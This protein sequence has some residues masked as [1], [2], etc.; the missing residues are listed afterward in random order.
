MQDRAFIP[1]IQIR[2]ASVILY[3]LP[4]P[5]FEHRRNVCRYKYTGI[6]TKSTAKRIARTCDILLQI[7]PPKTVWNPITQSPCTFRLTFL[8]LT[9]SK[10][11]AVSAKEGYKLGLS[12]FLDWLRKKGATEYIWKAELQ[13]RGQLHYHITTNQFLRFDEI[14]HKWN[15]LQRSAGWSED[16]WKREG[17]WHPN[18]T[19]IHAV[20]NVKRLD[21]YLAKYMAKGDPTKSIDGKVWG[22]SRHLMG[23]RYYSSVMEYDNADSIEAARK[24]KRAELTRLEH[25]TIV[26][27]DTPLQILTATQKEQYT[28]WQ[29]TRETRRQV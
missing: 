5:P 3:D 6:V 24:A 10:T 25:C 28:N 9:I 27:T 7:S 12:P 17:H 20:R 23:K 18:S 19:D 8:T 13:K 26:A 29:K 1:H 11:E 2:A 22:C 15:D 21:L 16:Y 4:E 14:K